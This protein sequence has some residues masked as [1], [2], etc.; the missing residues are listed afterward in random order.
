MR[1]SDTRIVANGDQCELRANVNLD[2]HWVWGDAPFELWYS[3]PAAYREY[4][5]ASNG[6]PFFAAFLFPAMALGEPLVIEATVSPLLLD[7]VPK[8]FEVVRCWN[9]NL[10]LTDVEAPRRD[11]A[12][13]VPDR[14]GHHGLFFSMGVDSSYSL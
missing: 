5:D 12:G 1:I 11:V 3:F 6:D 14:S 9:R 10:T 13:P 7:A 2:T 8:I 4:L